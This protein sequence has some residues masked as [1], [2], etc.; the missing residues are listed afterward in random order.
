MQCNEFLG[1]ALCNFEVWNG[2]VYFLYHIVADLNSFQEFNWLTPVWTGGASKS[3]DW[4]NENKHKYSEVNFYAHQILQLPYK[5]MHI[6]V[7]IT[8]RQLINNRIEATNRL[9]FNKYLVWLKL[10][11]QKISVNTNIGKMGI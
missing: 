1:M 5:D 8:K 6:P 10:N 3:G 11:R 7:I 9:F 4:N 2:H